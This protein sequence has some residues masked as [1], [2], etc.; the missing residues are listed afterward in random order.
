[1]EKDDILF[2]LIL[3]LDEMGVPVGQCKDALALFIATGTTGACHLP[4]K[5][6]D[7]NN[8]QIHYVILCEKEP[9]GGYFFSRMRFCLVTDPIIQHIEFNKIDTARLAE[10]MSAIDWNDADVV[11][12]L[13]HIKRRGMSEEKFKEIFQI[14]HDIYYLMTCPNSHAVGISYQLQQRF[15]F[16]NNLG[17]ALG[18]DPAVPAF[19]PNLNCEIDLTRNRF[20][21]DELSCMVQHQPICKQVLTIPD[22]NQKIWYLFSRSEYNEN[23]YVRINHYPYFDLN[24]LLDQ[25][26]FKLAIPDRDQSI[27]RLENGKGVLSLGEG[28]I[29]KINVDVARQCLVF[30]DMVG[31]EFTMEEAIIRDRDRVLLRQQIQKE[32]ARGKG[33]RKRF[34]RNWLRRKGK[35]GFS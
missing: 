4:I 22:G 17:N 14:F 27:L 28:A 26:P 24:L 13:S 3:Q 32:I 33:N 23:G 8:N 29:F 31:N 18:M 34:P 12:A 9:E 1:M 6:T 7:F 20:T 11:Y 2:D 35:G 21:L 19:N 10:R 25:V 16:G 15:W 30:T 5:D